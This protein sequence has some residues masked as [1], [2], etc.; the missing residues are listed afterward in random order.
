MLTT[1][2]AAF[3]EKL[4]DTARTVIQPYF[5]SGLGVM[6]KADDSP[7][8]KAD[9]EAEQAMRQLI[10][11]AYPDHGI[12]GEEFGIKEG[13]GDQTWVLDPIDGTRSFICG[14]PWFGTLIALTQK[15]LPHL[16][17]L[18]VPMMGER[19]IGDGQQTFFQGQPCQVRTT[20]AL[21]QASLFTTDF[22]LFT[23]EQGAAFNRVKEQVKTVRYGT[24][25]YA[26]GLLAGGHIDAVIEA[27]L[28]PYDA[29]A[30][31]PVIQGAGGVV[32]GWDGEAVSLQW[33]GRIVAAATPE[34]HAALLKVLNGTS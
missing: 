29:M 18:D 12:Y 13:A 26:Y 5:R 3:A 19:W 28:Q 2:E 34:L 7:V 14:A 32:T 6:D 16:G 27:G 22:D 23:P 25:C 9:R 31:V 24:D 17:V 33:D 10:E 20:T 4:A 15:G 8:T 11:Q 21:D 30:L 1:P